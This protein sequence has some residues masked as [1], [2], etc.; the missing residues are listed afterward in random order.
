MMC[1]LYELPRYRHHIDLETRKT[2]GD[3]S[4]SW[5]CRRP[6][7]DAVGAA[8]RMGDAMLGLAAVAST[9]PAWAGTAAATLLNMVAISVC[10]VCS[11]KS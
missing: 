4:F 3:L 1:G 10:A 9:R 11:D 7:V 2:K 6:T 8:V 5:Y